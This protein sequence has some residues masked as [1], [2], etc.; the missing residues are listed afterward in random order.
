M[1]LSVARRWGAIPT[2]AYRHDICCT[3]RPT[4]AQAY[5]QQNKKKQSK[6]H[7]FHW[8]RHLRRWRWR[9]IIEWDSRGETKRQFWV[10]D[11][12]VKFHFAAMKSDDR[13]DKGREERGV[14]QWAVN[15][16]SASQERMLMQFPKW[17]IVTVSLL[18][19]AYQNDSLHSLGKINSSKS[20]NWPFVR[21]INILWMCRGREERCSSSLVT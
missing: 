3:P 21:L 19:L 20:S 13:G 10:Y 4:H 7:K 8:E 2:R 16:C 5:R 17:A 18:K 1:R 12:K 9:Q 14:Q 15:E 6:K 11:S